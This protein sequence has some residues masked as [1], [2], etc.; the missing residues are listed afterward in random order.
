[1]I[2]P[3]DH[4][5]LDRKEGSRHGAS[6]P[7]RRGNKIIIGSRGREGGREGGRE[8]GRDLS[9]REEE[10]GKVNRILFVRR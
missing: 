6:I 9:G 7:G 2:H 5:K 10:E 4:K 3:S 1:M 8:E